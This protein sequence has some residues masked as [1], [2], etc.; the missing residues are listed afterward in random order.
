MTAVTPFASVLE[1]D[2]V[3]ALGPETLTFLQG[4]LSQDIDMP[5]GESRWSLLLA[6]T[7]KVDAWL[8]VTRTGDDEFVLDTDAGFGDAALSRLERFKLRTKCEFELTHERCVAV[9]GVE[10]DVLNARPIVWP[11]A[12]GVDV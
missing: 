7:G 4:Q 5:I 3:R 9:R 1:R 8:R 12:S 6:P 2:V 11:G 10:L